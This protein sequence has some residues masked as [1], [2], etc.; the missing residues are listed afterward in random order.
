[1]PKQHQPEPDRTTVYREHA[2]PPHGR[3]GGLVQDRNV[4][5]Y[6]RRLAKLLRAGRIVDRGH[7]SLT[8]PVWTSIYT[9]RRLP[10]MRLAANACLALGALAVALVFA[11]LGL[12]AFGVSYPSFLRPDPVTG[13]AHPPGAA[14]WF[15]LEGKGYVRIN[16][17]GWR[18]AD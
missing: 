6:E 9:A 5:I 7:E 13:W 3:D 8:P 1:M 14:G 16:A 10:C 18:G 11:E 4:E 2:V 17:A 12:R 15:T